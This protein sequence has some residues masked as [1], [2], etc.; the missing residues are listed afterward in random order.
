MSC[1]LYTFVLILFF[2]IYITQQKLAIRSFETIQR[3]RTDKHVYEQF[4]HN[5][6]TLVGQFTRRKMNGT[7]SDHHKDDVYKTGKTVK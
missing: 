4:T 6:T 1:A 5:Y 2:Q 3:P 7:N